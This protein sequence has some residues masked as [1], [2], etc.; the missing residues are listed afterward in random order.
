MVFAF[1]QKLAAWAS[2]TSKEV[3]VFESE[4]LNILNPRRTLVVTSALLV[5]TRSY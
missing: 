5:V 3:V 4:D 1:R 2:P